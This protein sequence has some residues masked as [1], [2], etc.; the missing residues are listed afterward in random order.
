MF[1]EITWAVGC[2]HPPPPCQ[3][4]CDVNTESEISLSLDWLRS[5]H[6]WPP[7]SPDFSCVGHKKDV[8]ERKVD[9]RVDFIV[10]TVDVAT[11]Q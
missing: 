4:T 9:T 7:R 6:T 11:L 10:G 5:P 3:Y 2:G 1:R 8:C